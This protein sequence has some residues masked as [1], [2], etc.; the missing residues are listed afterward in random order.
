MK[1]IGV[2]LILL[3][4]I[5][6]GSCSKS[7]DV[8]EPAKGLE[9]IIIPDGFQFNTTKDIDIV[10]KVNSDGTEKYKRI[11]FFIF[12]GDP[13]ASGVLLSTG[14]VNDQGIYQTVLS[15]PTTGDSL[16]I[17]SNVVGISL[18]MVKL[19]GN[20]FSYEFELNS[21]SLKLSAT[22]SQSEFTDI[23]SD[24]ENGLDGWQPYRDNSVFTSDAANTPLTQGPGG[25]N[26]KFIW[27]FD[28]QGGV[29]AWLAPAK[30]SGDIYGQYIA[31][32]Y[33]LGNTVAAAATQ[34]N[35]ADIRI[36]DG[37]NVL[38]I[39][40]SATF[41]HE[42]NAGWQTI[43]CKLDETETSGSA[44]RIGNMSIWTTSA[45]N[46]TTPATVASPAQIQLILRNVTG[47][48]IGPERQVGYFSVNG[49][50]FIA[51][52]KVGIVSDV[53]SF[54][55]IQQGEE[56][57][58]DDGDGVPNSTDDY[59]SDP[60]KAY[61][62]YSPGKDI[63]ATLAYEDLWPG[64][65]DYDFND[66]VIDYNFNVVTNAANKVVEMKSNFVL[67]ATGAG[68]L[69]GFAFELPVSPSTVT[70][71]SGQ[72]LND[73]V[74]SLNDNGSEANQTKAVIIV[75]DDAHKLFD[76]E[77][78][79]N[80]VPELPYNEPVS[81]QVVVSFDGSF[82]M[83]ELGTAPYNPFII[84][85]QLRGYEIHLSGHANTDLADEALFSTQQD[86]T[87]PS[88]GKYYQTANN[89]PWAIHIPVSFDYPIE[90]VSIE[91]AHL[92]FVEWAESGGVSY[93]DWYLNNNSYRNSSL[94]YT[95]N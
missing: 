21:P 23:I 94:I 61:N 74:F 9:S 4:S 86:D 16:Y 56:I 68:F 88:N 32:H 1:K 64:K 93:P 30:F 45:G 26:D 25:P 29:R 79:V 35:I 54:P 5:F 34:A 89:L 52:G 17:S 19:Q 8:S 76:L 75:F 33:Y 57:N 41:Q 40:L 10:L 92:K 62:N 78:F 48:L 22:R 44:W 46:L 81:V 42:V 14:G 20:S 51:L 12:S 27:G 38:A 77:G 31:Y 90:T 84:A 73:N 13:D 18:G 80:T 7:S 87:N 3:I 59:P 63:Y 82:S 43:Y 15:L 36:T 85:N 39:D 71:V 11:K 6:L 53:S 91:N 66:V 95:R 2:S 24:F 83:A 28:T 50:E 69:N 65:G 47:I 67:K 55:I 49:P 58:D 70:A 37:N 72:D 60:D